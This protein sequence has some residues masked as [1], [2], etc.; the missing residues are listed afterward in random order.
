MKK[1]IKF[2]DLFMNK[3]VKEA[4]TLMAF[5][6]ILTFGLIV[7]TVLWNGDG[8]AGK[9]ILISTGVFLVGTRAVET[10]FKIKDEKLDKKLNEAIDKH[11]SLLLEL[12]ALRRTKES[13]DIHKLFW[14]YMHKDKEEVNGKE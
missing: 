10:Y 8:L 13:K 9:I 4:M 3:L 11:I 12:K 5:L 2:I 7:V 14:D 1:A 6:L